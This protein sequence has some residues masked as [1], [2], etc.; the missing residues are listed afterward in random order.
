MPIVAVLNS[1]ETYDDAKGQFVQMGEPEE[2]TFE[3]SLVSVALWEARWQRAFL[4]NTLTREQ[5]LDY[6]GRCM[7]IS[8]TKLTAPE[9]IVRLSYEDAE[10]ISAYMKSKETA[11]VVVRL[12]AKKPSE[13]KAVT[14][15][16]IYYYM[17][18][19]GI[20]IEFERWHINR[21]L[22]FIDLM[23]LKREEQSNKDKPFK[24]T[25]AQNKARSELNA[26][27]LKQAGLK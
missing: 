22:T 24:P 23:S 7:V 8:P 17:V 26:A 20:P 1:I 6:V 12:G 10:R 27:R 21:L 14:N 13:E 19:L 11:T 9:I 15:E 16:L 3:H 18:E 2:I 5:Q 25:A 4:T